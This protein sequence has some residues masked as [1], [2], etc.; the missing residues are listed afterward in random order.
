MR[1]NTCVI[2]G[3]EFQPREGKL[4]CSNACKQKGY[5]DKKMQVGER[6]E[7]EQEIKTTR[8]QLQFYYYEFEQY[9]SKYPDGVGTFIIYCFFRK[10]LAGVISIEQVNKYIESFDSC[11]WN[12]FWGRT[13][14]G[15]DTGTVAPSRK[16][17]L[18]FEAT[19][20]GD[21]V[22]I[23]FENKAV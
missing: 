5:S 13:D 21:E 4:Y 8:K 7:K 11:W 15:E 10:N 3:T 20:F 22:V 6:E 23:S 2:C 17:Y 9:K 18:E 16:K 14:W 19:Y 1:N 12:A